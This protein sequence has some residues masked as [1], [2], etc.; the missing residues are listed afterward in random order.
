LRLGS[1][2]RWSNRRTKLLACIAKKEDNKW[3]EQYAEFEDYDGMPK[4]GSALFIWN[5]NQLVRF[6]ANIKKEIAANDGSTVWSNRRTKLLACIAKKENDKWEEQYAEFKDC[7]RMPKR[8]NTLYKWQWNQFE[9]FEARIKKEIAAN[10]DS[11]V[12]SNRRTKLEACIGKKKSARK[13][14][15]TK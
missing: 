13:T 1:R 3:E 10:K 7:D 8:G 11:T 2:R 6:E 14:A 9:R 12:W 5:R 15:L 4:T